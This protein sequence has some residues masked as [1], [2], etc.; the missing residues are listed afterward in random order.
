MMRR[1]DKIL[2]IIIII[3]VASGYGFKLYSDYKYR[4]KDKSV[5]IEINNKF[6][7]KYD[8][9]KVGNSTIT[10]G[11]L[12]G[13]HSVVEFKD[14]SVRIKEANC[15]DKVCVRTGFISNPGEMIVCLPYRVVIKI[16]GERQDVDII[17]F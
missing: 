3:F 13:E 17:T 12:Q 7:K 1:G 15:H 6:Y 5:T 4:D 10:L 11:L 14:G 8:L 16:S 2:I 9:K